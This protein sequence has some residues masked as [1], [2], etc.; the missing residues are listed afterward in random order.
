M[1]AIVGAVI[2]MGWGLYFATA[3]KA[4]PIGPMVFALAYITQPVAAAVEYFH[5][6]G[7]VVREVIDVHRPEPSDVPFGVT[8]AV[9]WNAG[10]FALIGLIVEVLRR[11]NH[12]LGSA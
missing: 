7:N 3:D 8:A 10:A 11:H 4:I 12:A 1:W 2:A 5:F 6:D 9:V